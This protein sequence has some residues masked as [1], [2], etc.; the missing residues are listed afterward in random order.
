M[1]SKILLAVGANKFRH[2]VRHSTQLTNLYFLYYL[3]VDDANAAAH[4][5]LTNNFPIFLFNDA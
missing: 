3:S 4:W 2:D 1:R 5:V